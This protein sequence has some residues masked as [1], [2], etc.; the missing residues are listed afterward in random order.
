MHIKELE[1]YKPKPEDIEVFGELN[2]LIDR[3]I[4]SHKV[5]MALAALYMF[6]RPYGDSRPFTPN[7]IEGITLISKLSPGGKLKL[8]STLI[9]QVKG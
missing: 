6:A 3:Q 2:S 5:E 1:D 7:F 4:K 9:E 8:V